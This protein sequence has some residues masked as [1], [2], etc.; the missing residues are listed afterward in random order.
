MTVP[1]RVL[2]KR[3]SNQHQQEFIASVVFSKASEPEEGLKSRIDIN[4]KADASE[5][6]ALS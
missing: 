2:V 3:K 1:S 5:Q 6:Y 4:T